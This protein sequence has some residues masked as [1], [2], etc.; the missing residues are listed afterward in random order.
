MDRD[1]LKYL[2]WAACAGLGFSVPA[3]AASGGGDIERG[4]R[5]ALACMAC[6]S[7]VPGEHLTGPSLTGIWNRKAGTAAG[8]ARYSHALKESNLVWDEDR[9]DAWLTKAIAVVPGNQM[10]FAGIA[11]TQTRADVLSYRRVTSERQ[12]PVAQRRLP[13]LN[14]A[15]ASD[16]VRSIRYCGDGYRRF[17]PGAFDLVAVAMSY[18][19]P[20]Y[21]RNDAAQR[22]LPFRIL[23]DQGAA[24]ATAFDHMNLTPTAILVDKDGRILRRIVGEPD[25][26]A[27]A[28][29]IEQEIKR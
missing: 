2:L 9:L 4:A 29:L 5:A 19:P 23:L 11:D 15:K 21:V 8:F 28:T 3:D 6:H 1:P 18:D 14:A 7:L 12:A 20:E 13:D 24:I 16:Q 25:F 27:L 22:Q 26:P 10:N 17:A